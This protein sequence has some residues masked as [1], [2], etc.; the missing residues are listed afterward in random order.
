MSRWIPIAGNPTNDQS[1]YKVGIYSIALTDYTVRVFNAVSGIQLPNAVGNLGKIFIVIGSNG[2]TTKNWTT[3]GGGIYDDVTNTTY[4]TIS[5][6]Q[7]FMVQ[8][9]GINWIVIGG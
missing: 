3:L 6:N 5:A 1:C 4:T 2:I 8:S 7:R 9:D